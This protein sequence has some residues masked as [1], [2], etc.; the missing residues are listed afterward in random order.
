LV[1]ALNGESKGS[2]TKNGGFSSPRHGI[3]TQTQDIA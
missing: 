3:T 2:L 1:S